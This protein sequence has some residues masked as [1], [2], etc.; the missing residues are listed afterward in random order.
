MA[1]NSVNGNGYRHYAQF[2]R[3][4]AERLNVQ[5][6]P[7]RLGY[8]REQ[9]NGERNKFMLWEAFWLLVAVTLA[10][11]VLMLAAVEFGVPLPEPVAFRAE[12]FHFQVVM[13]DNTSAWLVTTASA[14]LFV[15][16]AGLAVSPIILYADA[17]NDL[18]QARRSIKSFGR[19]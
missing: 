6:T 9:I 19:G 8:L 10:I 12:A 13:L 2:L 14:L 4:S 7:D 3:I 1:S 17:L 16:A 15:V 18:E 11:P 5:V